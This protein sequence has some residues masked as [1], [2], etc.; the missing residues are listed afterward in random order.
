MSNTAQKYRPF[1]LEMLAIFVGITASFWVADYATKLEEKNLTK[2]YLAGFIRDLE[3]DTTALNELIEIRNKQ[4]K[5]VLTIL[6]LI[7]SKTLDVDSFYN[8]YY[9][10]FPFYRFIP[11]INTLEE[12]LNSSHLR[13]IPD[14]SLKNSILELRASYSTI[15]LNE[16]HIYHDRMAYLYNEI[17]MANIELSGL[18]VA[19]ENGSFSSG[20]DAA[21][22]KQDAEYFLQDRYFKS[23]L[24]LLELNLQYVTPRLEQARDDCLNIIS[25]IEKQLR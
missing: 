16:E 19:E 18:F 12:V 7:E 13:L 11:N 5:S 1:F 6:K 2:K 23:F 21:V 22:Y 10:I 8:S 3:K 14:E 25:Q 15:K 17:T 9:F 4:S 24:N 20:K